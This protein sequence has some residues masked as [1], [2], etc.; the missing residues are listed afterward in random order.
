LIDCSLSERRAQ[1][2]DLGA[3]SHGQHIRG[4]KKFKWLIA[5]QASGEHKQWILVLRAVDSFKIRDQKFNWLISVQ[6]SGDLV[7]TAVD[8]AKI[9]NE[10]FN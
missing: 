1:A 7:Q 2:A 9:R 5:V 6:A 4:N 8:S 3:D 10:N